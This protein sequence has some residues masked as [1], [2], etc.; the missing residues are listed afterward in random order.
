M[1]KSITP[2]Q[3]N[4]SENLDCQNKSGCAVIE[5]GKDTVHGLLKSNF[6]QHWGNDSTSFSMK[7]C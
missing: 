4:S 3:P 1:S 7:H 6:P 5:K 2:T